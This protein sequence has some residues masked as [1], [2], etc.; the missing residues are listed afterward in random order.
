MTHQHLRSSAFAV[1]ALAAAATLAAAPLKFDFKDPKG[2]NNVQF[3]LDAPLESISGQSTGI[4]GEVTF[5]PAAP[6]ATTGKIV[7]AS[8]TLTVGNAMMKDHLQ[9]PGWIDA[10]KFPEV[11]FELKSLGNVKTA[12]TSSTADATGT[13]TVHGVAKEVTVPVSLNYLEG[14]LG[15]RVQGANGDLLVVRSTFAINRSDYGIKAGQMTDKVAEKIEITLSLAGAY[16][17]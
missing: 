8:N 1:L 7:V 6:A 5:D 2:V 9:S 13:L 16:A 17:K 14:K 12:G 15:S 4:T 3:H 11:T 10:A